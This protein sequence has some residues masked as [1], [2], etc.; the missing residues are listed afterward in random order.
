MKVV[1]FCGGLG[2]RIR[3]QSENVPK[4]MVTISYRPILWHLMKY[5]SYYGHKDFILCLGYKA[6]VIKNY[7]L[8]YEEALSNDFIL[9]NG[10]KNIQLLNSDIHDWEITFVDTGL[11]SN[12]GQRL[13]A[14]EPYLEGEDIFMAN[15]SDGLTDL[16]LPKLIDHFYKS[17]KVA[18]FLCVSPSQSI[19]IVSMNKDNIVKKTSSISKSGLLMNGGFFIFKKDIFRYIKEGEELVQEPFQRLI[20]EDELIAYKYDGFWACMDTFKEKQNLEEICSRG[21]APWEI[22]NSSLKEIDT[23]SSP[24]KRCKG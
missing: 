23:S 7:F 12:I 24:G 20:E 8:H 4:P 16:P 14:I 22:W 11:H 18:C 6:D 5:Y 17:N 2:M 9:T 13:K 21:E 15:Y 1:L 3:E 10:G 19:H